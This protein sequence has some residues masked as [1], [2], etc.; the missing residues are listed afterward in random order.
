MSATVSTRSCI[1]GALTV[2][3]CG[4]PIASLKRD[5]SFYLKYTEATVSFKQEIAEDQGVEPDKNME[6]CGPRKA[7][8][9]NLVP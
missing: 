9:A 1:P 5:W 2:G 3:T 8:A 7:R 6:R 4:W